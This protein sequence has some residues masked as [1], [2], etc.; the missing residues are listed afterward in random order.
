MPLVYE[1]EH[2]TKRYPKQPHPAND[3][4]SLTVEQGEFFGLLGDNGAGKTTLVRQMA[5]LLKPTSG[6]VR[7]FGK[8]IDDQQD[9]A[10][11][12]IG[13]MPQSS[14]ALN[15]LTVSEALYFTAHLR[16]RSRADS[17]AIR[18]TLIGQLSLDSIRSK[19]ILNLSGGQR[20]LVLLGATLA[21]R[22]PVLIL[23]EPTNDLA[24]QV[25]VQVWDLLRQVN[26]QDATTIILVTHNVL[27]AEKVIQ[28]VGIMKAGKL[29][30][31]GRPGILKKQLGD[32]LRLEVIFQPDVPP[33]LPASA[34]VPRE[35]AP[36]HWLLLIDPHEAAVIL[37]ALQAAPGLEDFRLSTPTL[38]DLYLAMVSQN[39]S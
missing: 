34:G 25:R 26:Q 2:L 12:Q 31:V 18:D 27:E 39:L 1:I 4:V 36:G 28:R 14:L 8:P 5:N 7:L 9:Y 29:N 19:P 3:D 38:E 24:P 6:I 15:N 10:A 22:P 32:R 16:G 33:V 35:V 11:R 30:V 21:A 23:D 13:Y 37:A 17:R 20:R